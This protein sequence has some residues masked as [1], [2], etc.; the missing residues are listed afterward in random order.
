VRVYPVENLSSKLE[1]LGFKSLGASL[2]IAIE[3]IRSLNF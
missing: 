1:Q 3:K 2:K